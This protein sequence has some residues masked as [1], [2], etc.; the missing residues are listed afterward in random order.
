[1]ERKEE[2]LITL[3]R[4]WEPRSSFILLV[5]GSGGVA[6]WP[7]ADSKHAEVGVCGKGILTPY[8]SEGHR[9]S[10]NFQ[11]HSLKSPWYILERELFMVNESSD[12]CCALAPTAPHNGYIHWQSITGHTTLPTV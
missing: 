12:Q 11:F 4:H 8:K 10:P 1:M 9:C 7:L 2:R 6:S 5:S 3:L